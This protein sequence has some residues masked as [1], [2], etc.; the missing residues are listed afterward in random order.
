MKRILPGA[1]LAA[2]LIQSPV[3]AQPMLR[4]EAWSCSLD[5]IGSTLT[6]CEQALEPGIGH[7]YITDVIAQSTGLASVTFSLKTGTGA[8]C[9]TGTEILLLKSAV[10]NRLAVTANL[11]PTDISLKTPIQIPRDQD[12]CVL[13]G[14]QTS[15]V[16]QIQGIVGP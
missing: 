2:L 4:G 9:G 8:N 13:G 10:G 15:V 3:K 14:T 12:L 7:K 1:I 16:V 11:L 6:L 5:D